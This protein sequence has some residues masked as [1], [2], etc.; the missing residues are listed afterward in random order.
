M[1]IVYY[2]IVIIIIIIII[3]NREVMNVTVY[4]IVYSQRK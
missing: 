3:R 2:Y 1:N 4:V